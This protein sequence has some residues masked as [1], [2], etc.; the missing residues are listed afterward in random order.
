MVKTELGRAFLA[1]TAALTAPA[2]RALLKDPKTE[3][4]YSPVAATKLDP[5]VRKTLVRVGDRDV[6]DF[7][8]NTYHGT[9]LAYARAIDLIGAAGVKPGAGQRLGDFGFGS[10]GQLRMLATLGFDTVGIEVS[11]F[12]VDLYSDP[13]DQGRFGKGSVKMV[14][15]HYPGD[16]AVAEAV[17]GGLDVFLSK[18]T[19]KRGYIHPYRTPGQPDW[20]IHLGVTDEVFLKTV[21]DA[22]KPGGLFMIYNICPALTPEDKPFVT[23]T[24]GRSPF[25]RDQFAAAGFREIAFDIDDTGFVRE[26]GRR[27]HWDRGADAMDLD[28]DLSVIYTLVRRI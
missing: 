9:P 18:N 23:W 8:Y 3:R 15:G 10:V 6:T 26:M 28:H 14:F 5:D 1:S 19:L 4:Y 22:I 20:V 11:P 16:A 25:T 27:L 13:T 7:F 24:D 12:L 2:P 17:G 21:H